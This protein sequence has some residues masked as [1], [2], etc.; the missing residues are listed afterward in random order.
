MPSSVLERR[1]GRAQGADEI[2]DAWRALLVMAKL[3]T[4]LTDSI[5]LS[6][7]LNAHVMAGNVARVGEDHSQR[8]RLGE[9][10]LAK[11]LDDDGKSDEAEKACNLALEHAKLAGDPG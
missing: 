10:A 6:D 8:V 7:R 9:L 5:P 1:I 3:G 2:E 11:E 4:R